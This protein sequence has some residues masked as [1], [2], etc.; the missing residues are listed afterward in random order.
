[1]NQAIQAIARALAQE[2]VCVPPLR[3]STTRGQQTLAGTPHSPTSRRFDRALLAVAAARLRRSVSSRDLALE[4]LP[5]NIDGNGLRCAAQA[6]G[7]ITEPAPPFRV[8]L[9]LG[10]F[11]ES[12]DQLLD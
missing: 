3:R 9:L 1:M 4:H 11:V 7:N 12:G 2:R 5:R 10:G 6:T 8:R